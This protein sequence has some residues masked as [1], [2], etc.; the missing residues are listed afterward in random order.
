MKHESGMDKFSFSLVGSVKI[1]LS[2]SLSIAFFSHTLLP[3]FPLA[4]QLHRESIKAGIVGKM[5][6]G[7]CDFPPASSLLS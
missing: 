2:L 1:S 3:L 6:A 5:I 4:N 7:C